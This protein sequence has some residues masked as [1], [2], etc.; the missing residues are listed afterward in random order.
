MG[1]RYGPQR[2]PGAG[3]A[4]AVP[5]LDAE[6]RA[7]GGAEYVAAV[8]VEEAVGPPVERGPA[9]RAGI[10]IGRERATAADDEDAEARGIGAEPEPLPLAIGYLGEAAEQPSAHALTPAILQMTRHSASPTAE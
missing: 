10:L 1:Y 5:I 6:E 2:R 7:M 3:S 4:E 8:A 9:M